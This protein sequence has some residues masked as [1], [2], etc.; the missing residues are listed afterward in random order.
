VAGELAGESFRGAA[1]QECGGDVGVDDD[2]AHARPVR[3]EACGIVDP[4]RLHPAARLSAS[5]P[6]L[7]TPGE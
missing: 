3:R 2:E 6:V 1:A 7:S 5:V 4:G